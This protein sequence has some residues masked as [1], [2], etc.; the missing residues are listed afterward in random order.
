MIAASVIF[1]V[2]F[3]LW[4]LW[5][6]RQRVARSTAPGDTGRLHQIDL[7]AFR[8]L[9]SAEDEE[10]LR[11]SLTSAHYRQVRRARLR[12]MQQY[13]IW[14]SEDCAVLIPLLQ[15]QA[16]SDPSAIWEMASLIRSASQI[17]VL[18][19]VLWALL[20]TEYFFPS[21]RIQPLRLLK[22]YEEFRTSAGASLILR[23]EAH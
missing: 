2:A 3:L 18:S 9:L 11:K 19:S 13:L 10:F 1:A 14:I 7:P 16:Q 4:L 21:L 5:L 23:T 17:R 20:W 12:A 6:L 8:N 22:R 15:Q